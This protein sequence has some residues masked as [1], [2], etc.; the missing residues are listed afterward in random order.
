MSICEVYGAYRPVSYITRNPTPP[1]FNF[2]DAI[3]GVK[4]VFI[5]YLVGFLKIAAVLR[6]AH[7]HAF[8]ACRWASDE[9]LANL[10]ST[11]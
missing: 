4:F 6:E 1:N 2:V 8:L 3:R 7:D 11:V 10:C 9:E 5:G